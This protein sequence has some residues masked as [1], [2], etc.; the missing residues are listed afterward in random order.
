MQRHVDTCEV[1]IT[2]HLEVSVRVWFPGG[3]AADLLGHHAQ[4]L[5]GGL[6]RG[7][8]EP[9]HVAAAG[10][11]VVS[12]VLLLHLLHQILQQKIFVVIINIFCDSKYFLGF[13]IF[14]G[15]PNI[16]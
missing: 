14:F 13:E 2:T 11:R 16:F 15:I 4:Q 6:N 8:D 3:L 7:V 12:V 9:G 10:H 1:L 5:V